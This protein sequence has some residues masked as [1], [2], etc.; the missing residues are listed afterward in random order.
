MLRSL[1]SPSH[2]LKKNKRK[3]EGSLFYFILFLNLTSQ[4]VK[5]LKY[6]IWKK[7]NWGVKKLERIL[8]SPTLGKI[9]KSK[10]M[11]LGSKGQGLRLYLHQIDTNKKLLTFY[12]N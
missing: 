9:L 3:I 10:S 4:K 1:N 7:R 11:P 2:I 6:F 8:N 5:T 12:S